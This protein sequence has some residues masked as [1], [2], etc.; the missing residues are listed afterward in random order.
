[1]PKSAKYWWHELLIFLGLE[2]EQVKAGL[3]IAPIA[4]PHKLKIVKPPKVPTR[5]A[6][7][8]KAKP[9]RRRAKSAR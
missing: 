2:P 9:K 8:A 5:K 4:A 1:M 3:V 7:R 6:R